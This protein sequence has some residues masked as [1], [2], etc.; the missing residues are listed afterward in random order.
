M[1]SSFPLD[2]VILK[3]VPE[4][5][6]VKNPLFGD[7]YWQMNQNE[8]SMQVE[9]VAN[10]YALNGKEIKYTPV[11]D[12]SPESILLYLNGSVYGAILHQR[13]IL[14]MHGSSFAINGRGVM[15]CGESGTGKSALTAAFSKND[16]NF[17]TDDVT[18]VVF[19]ENNPHILAL[20]DRI[21]LWNDT[22]EQLKLDKTGLKRISPETEKYYFKI[23]KSIPGLVPLSIIYLLEIHG[24]QET[25][26]TE[27]AGSER[28]SSLHNEI[29]RREFLNGMP[30]NEK[31]YFSNLVDIS[32]NVKI[33][34]VKRPEK[35]KVSD[36][37]SLLREH[38][39]HPYSRLR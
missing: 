37:S 12:A 31:I 30:E 35:V 17:L 20:S 5:S 33:Y 39:V 19:K 2:D 7:D 25:I 4:T 26:I 8:F 29:Y 34:R 9:G 36:L 22:L 18:P 15:L 10:F 11:D 6:R 1:P 3:K 23:D 21:K 27:S 13:H 16:C 38:I 24:N 32:N 28:F 14:P